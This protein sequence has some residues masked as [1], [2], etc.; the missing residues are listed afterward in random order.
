MR[1]P[2]FLMMIIPSQEKVEQGF[3]LE[4]VVDEPQ[5]L[6]D[7]GGPRAFFDQ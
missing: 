3:K 4:L 2:L 5:S 7:G 1:L 6:A